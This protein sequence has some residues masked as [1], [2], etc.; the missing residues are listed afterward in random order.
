M[1]ANTKDIVAK[2]NA[3]FAQN[4]MEAFLAF[5]ADDVEWTMVGDVTKK[6]KESIRQWMGS[7]PADAP[8]FDVKQVIAEGDFVVCY[9]DMTMQ[10]EQKV[11]TPYS[12]CDLYRFR[13]G[14]IAEL[15]SWVI[16]TAGK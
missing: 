12:Y 8:K 5:S 6:G 13:D 16:K 11:E 10:D 14:K 1:V 7:M 4:D 3:A 2:V 15:R 9:G